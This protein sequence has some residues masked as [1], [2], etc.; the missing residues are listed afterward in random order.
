[1]LLVAVN[2][3]AY[4]PELLREAIT[5]AKDGRGIELL[6][7]AADRYRNVRIDYRGGLRYPKLERLAGT[8]DRLTEILSALK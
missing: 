5:E 1:M 8:P 4:K 7:K 2:G 6:V 3:I